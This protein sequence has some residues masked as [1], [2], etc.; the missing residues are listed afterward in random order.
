MV[1]QPCTYIMASA[2]NGTLY[3]GMTSH[4]VA[5]VQQHREGSV[6]SFTLRYSVQIL[7]WFELLAT[8]EEAI[9]REKQ[10]KAWR[11][12]WKLNLIEASNPLWRD[13]AEDIGFPPL[14]P[15]S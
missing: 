15:S 4:I 9:A 1:K 13:L 12:S 7:V 5:R 2:R 6:E 11:R 10:I 8:M 14:P 3:T